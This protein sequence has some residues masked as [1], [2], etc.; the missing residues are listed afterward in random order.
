MKPIMKL[1]IANVVGVLLLASGGIGAACGAKAVATIPADIQTAV[2][3]LGQ[4]SYQPSCSLSGGGNWG[5]CVVAIESACG[6]DEATIATIVTA[7]EAANARLG[8]VPAL[9]SPPTGGKP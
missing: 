2:C 4:V 9:V 3:I 6:A 1:W 7:H 5:A 8:I